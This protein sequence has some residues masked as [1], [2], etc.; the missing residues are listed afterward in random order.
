[1][2]RS[3][4]QHGARHSGGRPSAR[5]REMYRLRTEERRSLREI[6]ERF[7]LSGERVR[8]L[9]VFHFGLTGGQLVDGDRSALVALGDACRQFREQRG[10]SVVEVAGSAGI[11]IDRLTALEAG[12]LDADIGLLKSFASSIRV[13]LSTILAK[14]EEF[15]GR[16]SA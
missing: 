12:Q 9:L 4:V 14:A 16:A 7:E 13:P 11:T 3:M 15:E 1:M 8:Q 10:L 2:M 5:E 6:G